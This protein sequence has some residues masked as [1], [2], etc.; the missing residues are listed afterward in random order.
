MIVTTPVTAP[1]TAKRNEQM[2]TAVVTP[3]RRGS[4]LWQPKMATRYTSPTKTAGRKRRG[5][6]LHA[7]EK[8]WGHDMTDTEKKS[9]QLK[10]RKERK[11]HTSHQHNHVRCDKA[12][13]EQEKNGKK[14]EKERKSKKKMGCDRIELPTYGL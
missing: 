9:A 10:R 3:R 14:G 7:E 8:K 13:I 1:V 11:N 2:W 4:H 6:R 12:V 5:V